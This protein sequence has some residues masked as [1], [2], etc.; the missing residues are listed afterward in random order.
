MAFRARK[1]FDKR[2][3]GNVRSITLSLNHQG[4]VVRKP[5]DLI[6]D[7]FH[8]F[9]FLVKISFAY[10]CVFQGLTFNMSVHFFSSECR[11]KRVL[12]P[13]KKLV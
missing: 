7:S 4:Q 9:N 2:V 3:P 13:A 12:S 8:V 10:F 5:I 6:Q 1:V 11:C